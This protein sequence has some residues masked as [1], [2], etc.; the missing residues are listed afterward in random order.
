M[1]DNFS[2]KIEYYNT[3]NLLHCFLRRNT[4]NNKTPQDLTCK[5]MYLNEEYY[6][7]YIQSFEFEFSSIIRAT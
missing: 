6:A 5:N 4:L 2:M 7:E 3:T 1:R